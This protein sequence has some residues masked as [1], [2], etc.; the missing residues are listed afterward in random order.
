MEAEARQDH[1]RLLLPAISELLAGDQP[2][3]ALVVIGPGAYAGIRV[4]IATAEGLG[5]A[6]G[7]P[8]YSIGTL[9]AAA[10]AAN[11][12]TGTM[13]HPAG[14]GAFAEQDWS[15]GEAIGRPVQS[16]PAALYGKH[17]FGEGAGALGGTEVGPRQRV[18]AALRDRAPKIR[19]GSIESGADAF[20][21]REPNITVS[22]RQQAAAS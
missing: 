7:I 6:L 20:Y 3:A 5:L 22:R 13:I 19:A 14:R 18:E 2:S 10:L 15:G 16:D 9:E 1:S 17:V 12:T 11:V 8:I 4:G 21:L